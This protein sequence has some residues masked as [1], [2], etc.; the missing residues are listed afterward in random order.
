MAKFVE[1]SRHRLQRLR[2]GHHTALGYIDKAR[3][4]KHEP[5]VIIVLWWK[6]AVCRWW[7]TGNRILHTPDAHPTAEHHI[8]AT[9]RSVGRRSSCHRSTRRCKV[10]RSRGVVSERRG[11][12]RGSRR[13]PTVRRR[14][15]VGRVSRT[16]PTD[17][18]TETG[19]RWHSRS[20]VSTYSFVRL[21]TYHVIG[22]ALL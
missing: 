3:T 20:R 9:T 21:D 10:R 18:P 15:I 12:V 11:Y 5:T 22:Q 16:E 13:R 2:L 8:R 19:T 6:L 1:L 7:I 4:R 17:R 14:R